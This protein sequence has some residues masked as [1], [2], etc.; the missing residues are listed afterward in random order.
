MF[1]N[2]VYVNLQFILQEADLT[3]HFAT[4]RELPPIS[5]QKHRSNSIVKK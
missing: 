2:S 5:I 4:Q 3:D 1:H